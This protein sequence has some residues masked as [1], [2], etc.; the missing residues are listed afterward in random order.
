MIGYDESTLTK[1]NVLNLTP[2]G[3]EGAIWQSWVRDSPLTGRASFFLDANGTFDTT[4][5]SKGFP[6]MATT[7]TAFIKVSDQGK[8]TQSRRLFQHV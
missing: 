7:E 2:N 5:N 6:S 1:T 3:S 8:Q 4:L